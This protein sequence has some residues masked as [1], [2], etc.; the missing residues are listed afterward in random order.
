MR[1]SQVD[2]ECTAWRLALLAAVAPLLL[3][4]AFGGGLLPRGYA[5][6]AEM[7]EALIERRW[8]EV[9][10]GALRLLA[11][12]QPS[13]LHHLLAGY[14]ALA[15]GEAAAAQVHFLALRRDED[16][17]RLHAWA[18]DLVRRHD[19]SPVAHLL[20]AD[21]LA[22]AGRLGDALASVGRAED[23]DGTD[24]IFLDVRGVLQALMG[25]RDEA[26]ADFRE[27]LARDREFTDALVNQG[28]LLH[29]AGDETASLDS[30]DRSVARA[31]EFAFAYN[32]RGV[33][34]MARG[35]WVQAARDLQR[36]ADLMP[37]LEEARENLD[38]LRRSAERAMSTRSVFSITFVVP[39]IRSEAD[40]EFFRSQ[41][42]ALPASRPV[43]EIYV[44][45]SGG[46]RGSAIPAGLEKAR[47]AGMET[48]LIDP[49]KPEAGIA[50]LNG[51]LGQK[52]QAGME[53]AVYAD[54]NKILPAQ[55][56]NFTAK[57]IDVPA[58]AI[59][60]GL[61]SFTA[62]A[63]S[64]NAAVNSRII[65]HSDG[66]WPGM[67]ATELATVLGI[68]FTSAHVQTPRS[69]PTL[70]KA[71]WTSP[72]TQ[73]T[74]VVAERGDY[75]AVANGGWGP[76]TGFLPHVVGGTSQD[77]AKITAPNYTVVEL[78]DTTR[79]RNPMEWLIRPAH[80]EVGNATRTF[81]VDVYR[82]GVGV[83]TLVTTLADLF[84]GARGSLQGPAG[85]PPLIL[86]TVERVPVAGVLPPA[87]PP[88]SGGI[89]LGNLS[90]S[91]SSSGKVTFHL[92]RG[93]K[94]ASAPKEAMRPAFMLYPAAV[95]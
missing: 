1:F 88:A 92:G 34:H 6:S 62:A 21:S 69:V 3:L 39:G 95:P 40:V 43:T 33:V 48:V 52:V 87:S 53:P 18:A 12:P 68:P 54:I 13:R 59:V 47:A 60:S 10:E 76:L 93:S 90:L 84:R 64:L 56:G 15:A 89:H 67:R 38:L 44:A 20:M 58:Q 16:T 73:F 74:A 19:G 55:A 57:T 82:G 5:L 86:Q 50:V 91:R 85:M 79:P 32:V 2:L 37:A 94:D 63:T 26:L 35:A 28:I 8:R 75:P 81:S 31:P 49:W 7:E 80:G 61:K 78:N 25:R 66:F 14:G 4:F 46:V 45:F 51:L 71:V 41:L 42:R 30:L 29:E 65:T 23:L 24:P 9:R 72:M 17:G 22:R 27:A 83:D 70:H 77:F 11:G 36:A